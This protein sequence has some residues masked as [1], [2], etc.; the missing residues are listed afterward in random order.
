MAEPALAAH[1]AAALDTL[2]AARPDEFAKDWQDTAAGEMAAW[3]N[4]GH[5]KLAAQR[6]K[7]FP[8]TMSHKHATELSSRLFVNWLSWRTNARSGTDKPPVAD[9][10]DQVLLHQAWGISPGSRELLAA[11]SQGPSREL[12]AEFD[13]FMADRRGRPVE[14]V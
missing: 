1:L 2:H 6:A 11:S 5:F 14:V 12:S 10:A 4:A 7:A 9:L 8:G 3:I 13:Q